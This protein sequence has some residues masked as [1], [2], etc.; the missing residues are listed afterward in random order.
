MGE[1]L[2]RGRSVERSVSSPGGSG[3]RQ[4]KT[5]AVLHMGSLAIVKMTAGAC[6]QPRPREQ[7][8]P[9]Q[10]RSCRGVIGPRVSTFPIGPARSSNALAH[11]CSRR[12]ASDVTP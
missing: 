6:G 5:M 1:V 2:S 9:A 7:E 12:L 10:G 8:G 11:R 4:L 3:R